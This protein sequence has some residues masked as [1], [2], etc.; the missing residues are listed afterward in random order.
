MNKN[1]RQLIV[2]IVILALLTAFMS[3]FWRNDF[4]L[5]TLLIGLFVA[6]NFVWEREPY[7]FSMYVITLILAP[8]VDIT[9]IPFGVW[10]YGTKPVFLGIPFWLPFCY[11]LVFLLFVKMGVT[12]WRIWNGK[13]N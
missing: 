3:L 2:Q 9:N 4:L 8:I 1:V 10:W 5:T 12:T 7:D 13:K 11:G 6:A